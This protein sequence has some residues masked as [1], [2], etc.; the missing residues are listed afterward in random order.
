MLRTRQRLSRSTISTL[1]RR[2]R[3]KW[4]MSSSS[5]TSSRRNRRVRGRTACQ[6]CQSDYPPILFRIGYVNESGSMCV[7]D[8]MCVS[9]P[10]LSIDSN[11]L[12]REQRSLITFHRDSKLP[13]SFISVFSLSSLHSSFNF[14]CCF[15]R[16]SREVSTFVHQA[17]RHF[18]HSFSISPNFCFSNY[19]DIL[20]FV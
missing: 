20:E 3:M 5:P 2:K 13:S 14:S 4:L 6:W 18:L 7:Y 9:W 10:R 11:L 17:W 15:L 1:S 19:M 12:I 8:H 16:Q